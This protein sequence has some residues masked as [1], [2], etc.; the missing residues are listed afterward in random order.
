MRA[1]WWWIDRWRTS[2]AYATLSMAEQGAY[3]N[4]LDELWLR[5]GFLPDDDRTLERASGAGS[6]WPKLKERVLDHFACVP[7][8]Y[9]HTTHDEVQEESKKRAARQKRYRD[10]HR[11][12]TDNVTHPVSRHIRPSPSL[13][14][15]PS[16]DP[17]PDLVSPPKTSGK[18]LSPGGD[19]PP[20]PPLALAWNETAQPAGLSC[21]SKVAPARSRHIASRL[22]EEPD[23]AIWRKAFALIAADPFC[24]GDNDRGWKAD[25]DY[26]LRPEKCG[27]WLDLARNGHAPAESAFDR[28]QRI[29]GDSPSEA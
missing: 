21:V 29:L 25:F 9:R 28:T 3:R 7:G 26:A 12:V 16:P 17:V 23:I 2:S 13:S 14:L 6:E 11:N 5:D 22:R 20:L 8:G 19:H 10:N 27:K 24:R 4:L 1:A 18:R 15:D